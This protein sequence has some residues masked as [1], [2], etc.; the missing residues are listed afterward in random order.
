[1]KVT[2]FVKSSAHSLDTTVS[3]NGE[4]KKLNLPAKTSGLGSAING[5]ELLLTALAVCYCNDIYREAA[6]RNINVTEV[7]VTCSGSFPAEGKPGENLKYNVIIEADANTDAIAD[8]ILHTDTIAEIH[9][10]IRN[11]TPV[12]MD[13][14]WSMPEH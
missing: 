8:L 10:T 1:M 5:G 9:L 11:G 7:E 3:T 6:K 14:E 2:A 4:H 13:D 12:E